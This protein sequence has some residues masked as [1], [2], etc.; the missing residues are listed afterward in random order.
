MKQAL[1]AV[2]VIGGIVVGYWKLRS[3]EL[4]FASAAGEVKTVERG[5]LTIPISAHGSVGPLAW[6]EV[7]SQASGEVVEIRRKPGELIKKGELLIRLDKEDEQRSVERADAEVTR[8]LAL[9]EQRKMNEQRLRTIGRDKAQ[10]Q[11]DQ[12]T[13]RLDRTA[14]NLEKIE[15]LDKEGRASAEELITIRTTHR[16]AKAQLDSAV[17]DLK[18]IDI[19]VQ[20]A[21][22][23]VVLAQAAYDQALSAQGD[24][25][26]RLSETDIYSPVDGMVV[27]INT[28]V[29]AVIQGG[30]NT[31]TAG[32]VLAVV[33]DQ[34][35]LYVRAE[36]DEADIGTVRNLSP[37]SARP[38][39]EAS[40]SNDLPI[41]ADTPVKIRV[42]T[43][44]DELFTGVIERIHPE[45]FSTLNKIV[46]Y[47]VDILLLSENSAKLLTGMQADV[48]F[49]AQSAL[50]VVL[51]PHEAI[52]RNEFDQLGVY[53]PVDIPESQ[54]KDDPTKAMK[55][56]PC[57]FGLDNG[58]Y[59]EVIEG[60]SVGQKVYTSLP[61]KVGRDK[62]S[63]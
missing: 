42:E 18:D 62:E 47:Q 36:V 3:L 60:L 40:N 32:T 13:A 17:A 24:A 61:K 49:T 51:A 26:Q 21:E 28:Q 46:T 50:D 53:V 44:H 39:Q 6:Y 59:A 54:A 10:A 9:L 48:E 63:E 56:V 25:N 16:D 14:F 43:F 38:G 5:D 45:P 30:L 7:K 8:T 2:L 11:V 15:A 19:Q 57:R 31:I 1:I 58:M 52:R 23:D 29:G 33:A 55:F 12:L 41:D 27:K 34:S 20:T 4:Q 35:K 22:K 37:E